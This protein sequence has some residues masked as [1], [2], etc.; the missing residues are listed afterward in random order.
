MLIEM[1]RRLTSFPERLSQEWTAPIY[2]FFHP[3]PAIKTYN[4]RRCHEF[5][6]AKKGCRKQPVRRFLDTTDAASTGSM[7]K[8][9]AR[10][11][12][13]KVLKYAKRSKTA[14]AA[15]PHVEA[16]GR[17]GQITEAFKRLAGSRVTYS[18]KPPT[19]EQTR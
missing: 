14:A 6:C 1:K 16:V 10:C 19:Q 17:T 13:S 5:K 2:A 15:R 7:H 11:W 3:I 9:A 4:G 12:G 8:H 18:S